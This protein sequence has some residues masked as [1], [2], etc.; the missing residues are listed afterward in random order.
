VK[1]NQPSTAMLLL[2]LVAVVGMLFSCIGVIVGGMLAF[3]IPT[4]F[5]GKFD[6]ASSLALLPLPLV[7]VALL[8]SLWRL[9]HLQRWAG[10]VLVVLGWPLA[11]WQAMNTGGVWMWAAGWIAGATLVTLVVVANW[12]SFK[13]GV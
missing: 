4:K 11:V 9:Y 6:L 2:R 13:R 1:E 5:T 10:V 3:G 7:P 12:S 8:V